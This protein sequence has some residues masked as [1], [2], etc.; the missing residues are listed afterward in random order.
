VLRLSANK[1]LYEVENNA[2]T[3]VTKKLKHGPRNN[4]QS[5]TNLEKLRAGEVT[6]R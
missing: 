3:A 5:L 4:A 2:S 1:Q 6:A